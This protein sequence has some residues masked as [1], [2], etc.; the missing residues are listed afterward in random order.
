MVN[1][2][3]GLSDV[4]IPYVYFDPERVPEGYLE[5][6]RKLFS[7]DY[8]ECGNCHQQ[9]DKKPDGPMEDWAPDLNM[10][11]ARLNPAWIEK[12]IREP[13]KLEPGTKMPSFYPGGPEDIL[14][15]N[16]KNQ[17]EA[18]TDYIMSLGVKP[19]MAT[20]VGEKPVEQEQKPPS[21]ENADKPG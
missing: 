6:G 10:A 11:H 12:W 17:I 9:G 3:D 21:V 7:K 14:A 15:G 8:F 20:A 1:Y 18:L 19:S 16:E 5:A 4:Q 2:F 13:Q